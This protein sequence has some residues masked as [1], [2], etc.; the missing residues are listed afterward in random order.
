[1]I[2]DIESLDQAAHRIALILFE[3]IHTKVSVN[4]V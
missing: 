4:V 3:G 1:M 2:D